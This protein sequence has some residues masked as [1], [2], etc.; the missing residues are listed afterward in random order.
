MDSE[1]VPIV[2]LVP[3]LCWECPACEELNPFDGR[4]WSDV[5]TLP[6]I[7]WNCLKF[8]KVARPKEAEEPV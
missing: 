5:D 8:Y 4:D 7:C 2:A 1:L 6:D 3:T